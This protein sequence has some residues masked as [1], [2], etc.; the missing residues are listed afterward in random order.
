MVRI[1][2]RFRLRKEIFTSKY[3]GSSFWISKYLGSEGTVSI[4]KTIERLGFGSFYLNETISNVVFESG[5]R[6]CSIKRSAFSGCSFLSSICIPASVRKLG[7]SC[8]FRCKSLSTVTFESGSTLSTIKISAFSYCSSLS[9]I[10]IPASVRW[11]GNECFSHCASLSTV[12]FESSAMLWCLG[13]SVFSECSS[14]SSIYC[15]SWL[16]TTLSEYRSLLKRHGADA[17]AESD[18]FLSSWDEVESDMETS[19]DNE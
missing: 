12:T 17:I 10:C 11:L 19:G 14:L 7:R 5:S 4:P 9:S 15:S 2:A 13:R 16:E 18:W 8:F 1:C 6:L 3:V